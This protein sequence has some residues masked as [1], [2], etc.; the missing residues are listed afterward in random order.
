MP[1]VVERPLGACTVT[2]MVSAWITELLNLHFAETVTRELSS[3][4]RTDGLTDTSVTSSTCAKALLLRI[5]ILINK[6]IL[7]LPMCY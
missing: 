5:R 3:S 1:S 2:R 6:N 4:Q 7:P